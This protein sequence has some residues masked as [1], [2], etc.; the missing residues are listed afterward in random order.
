M[1]V[2]EGW[3]PPHKATETRGGGATVGG[4]G[5]PPLQWPRPRVR[6]PKKTG[7]RQQATGK[8]GEGGVQG[9]RAEEEKRVSERE[10]PEEE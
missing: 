9:E 5:R 6:V 8:E 2:P 10:W 3:L 1:A 4:R 7:S